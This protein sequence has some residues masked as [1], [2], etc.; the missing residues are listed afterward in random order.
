MTAPLTAIARVLGNLRLT[1]SPHRPSWR[2]G[3][4]PADGWCEL[5]VGI[6]PKHWVAITLTEAPRTGPSRATRITI[7]PEAARILARHILDE[8]GPG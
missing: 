4:S 6:E 1:Q 5:R 8:L 3:R 2:D 7:G